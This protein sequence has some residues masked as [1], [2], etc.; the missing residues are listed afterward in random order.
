MSLMNEETEKTRQERKENL[1]EVIFLVLM[2]PAMFVALRF[3]RTFPYFWAIITVSA[4]LVSFD[5]W[6]HRK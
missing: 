1:Q 6:R 2:I 4:S 3:P 5:L